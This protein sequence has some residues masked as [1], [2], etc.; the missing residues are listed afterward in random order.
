MF[1]SW[2]D[3]S[4]SPDRKICHCQVNYFLPTP[5]A[6][7]PL[8]KIIY[9]WVC[10]Q[11]VLDKLTWVH[12]IRS[13][14]IFLIFPQARSNRNSVVW[15]K[16]LAL[17]FKFYKKKNPTRLLFSKNCLAQFDSSLRE[18]RIRLGFCK[19]CLDLLILFLF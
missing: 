15:K 6:F 18:T 19:A 5:R 7:R 4:D 2:S 14:F 9:T 13:G 10:T 11:I 17:H 8:F 16:K 3:F 1:F 12:F